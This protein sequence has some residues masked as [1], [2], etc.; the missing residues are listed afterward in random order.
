LKAFIDMVAVEAAGEFATS[1]ALAVSLAGRTHPVEILLKVRSIA[2]TAAKS[3][4]VAIR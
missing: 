4:I 2:G 3:D 1:G